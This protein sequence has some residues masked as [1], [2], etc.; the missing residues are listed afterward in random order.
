MLRRRGVNDMVKTAVSPPEI[1]TRPIF[2]P[3]STMGVNIEPSF[4]SSRVRR[5][6][7]C[8]VSSLT[9]SIGL[10]EKMRSTYRAFFVFNY[11][12][13]RAWACYEYFSI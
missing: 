6:E 4:T 7:V 1:Y 13:Q 8:V 3:L 12:V 2:S 5:G 9:S 11:D 10:D